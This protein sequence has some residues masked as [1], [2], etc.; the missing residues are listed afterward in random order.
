MR[1]KIITIYVLVFVLIIIVLAYYFLFNIYGNEISITP[2]YIYADTSSEVII[3]AVPINALG[4]K[5]I[6]RNLS[7]KFEIA[8][9]KDLVVII[10]SDEETGTLKIRSTG[11]TGIV[12]IKIKVNN[13][14]LPDYVELQ[15]LPLTV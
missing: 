15:I 13:A 10:K 14:L 1:Q 11:K 2:E 9:G 5:A 7:A 3:K 4:T 6:F 12:G 8:E